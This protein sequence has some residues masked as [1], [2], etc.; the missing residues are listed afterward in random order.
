MSVM[1]PSV[2]VMPSDVYDTQIEAKTPQR[3]NEIAKNGNKPIY[4][5]ELQTKEDI[6][7]YLVWASEFQGV[8][9]QLILD[10]CFWESNYNPKAQN[11]KS[12]AKGLFQWLDGS[13]ET[14]CSGDVFNPKDNADCAIRV[15]STG[16]IEHWSVDPNIKNLLKSNGYL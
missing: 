10:L 15:I 3:G 16:G 7:E 11:P 9:P 6:K 5:R 4:Q 14:Y 12:S 1:S 8:D 2:V 13:W